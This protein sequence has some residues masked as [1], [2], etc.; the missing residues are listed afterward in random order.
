[1][2][3]GTPSHLGSAPRSRVTVAALL[4]SV[5]AVG[6]YAIHER[7]VVEN[8]SSLAKIPISLIE[9]FSARPRNNLGSDRPGVVQTAALT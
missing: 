9:G 2:S 3:E 1:M 5:V 7:N 4:M 6:A 8:Q